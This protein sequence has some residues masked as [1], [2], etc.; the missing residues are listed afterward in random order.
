MFKPRKVGCTVRTRGGCA[1]VGGTV[2]KRGGTKNTGG[3][4]KI[5]KREVGKL[6]QG[7]GILKGGLK[8]PYEL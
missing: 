6:D 3:E 7:L 5:L 1:R 4:A 2:L 8:P